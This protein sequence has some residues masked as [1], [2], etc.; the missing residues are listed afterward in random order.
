VIHTMTIKYNLNIEKV[1]HITETLGYEEDSINFFLN[2]YSNRSQFKLENSLEPMNLSLRCQGIHEFKAYKL[3]T[4]G[5][6]SFYV[7]LKIEP[8]TLIKGIQHIALFECTDDNI[9]RFREVFRESISNLFDVSKEDKLTE[10]SNWQVNRVDYAYDSR[11]NNAD[12][13][14]AFINLCKWSVI[15]DRYNEKAYNSYGDKFFD[16]GLLYG[17]KSWQLAVYDKRKQVEDVYRDI[18]EDTRNRLLSEAENIVRIEFRAKKNKVKSLKSSLM[19]FLSETVAREQLD[20]TYGK[21]IGC[22]AFYSA[23]YAEKKLKET[24]PLTKNERREKRLQSAKYEE[25]R[26]FMINILKHKGM[27]NAYKA[28]L[29]FYSVEEKNNAKLRFKSRIKKIR[30]LNMSPILIPDDWRYSEKRLNLPNDSL[31]NP[32]HKE[33][34]SLQ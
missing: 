8:L 33:M 18:D 1:A 10:L 24:F 19:D 6:D 28:Y 34:G 20:N 2:D 12:E 31:R 11:M 26:A 30:E 29:N 15:E 32:I 17:N 21:Y 9:R 16:Y 7:Y 23:Y 13:V 4:N 22:E 14:T 3:N 5:F 27:N 25:Y